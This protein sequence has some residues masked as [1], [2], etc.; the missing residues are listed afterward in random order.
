MR[1]PVP[2]FTFTLPSVQ[3]DTTLD[4]RLYLPHADAYKA[5]RGAVIAHPYAPLGGSYDD[6]VVIT[7]AEKLLSLGWIVATFNFR[8]AGNAGKTSWSGKGELQDY[9]SVSGFLIAYLHLLRHQTTPDARGAGAKDLVVFAGYSYGSLIV[10][11]LPPVERILEPFSAPEEGTAAH[12][13]LLRA[14][15][16]AEETE[17]VQYL[18]SPG[19]EAAKK[20]HEGKSRHGAS[21]SV[22][23]GGEETPESL[24][25]RSGE[26]RRSID[27]HHLSSKVRHSLSR[28]RKSGEVDRRAQERPSMDELHKTMKWDIPVP[29]TAFLLISPLLPPV[30]TGLATSLHGQSG[31]KH[32]GA[33]SRHI[34]AIFGDSDFF[35]SAKRLVPWADKMI[36]ESAKN[37]EYEVV[38]GG[39]HFWREEGVLQQLKSRIAIW[40]GHLESQR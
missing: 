36:R 29:D 33:A 3:D 22:T 4:C 8:G 13:I 32:G 1:N 7:V 30:S 9:L 10:S 35:T 12:E 17:H 14:R 2:A 16:V 23:M 18:V 38:K 19:K 27:G 25:R 21:L 15:H 28:H 34:L 31:L 5:G 24:R 37:L 20:S 6:A 39:G 11:H 40:L 26:S